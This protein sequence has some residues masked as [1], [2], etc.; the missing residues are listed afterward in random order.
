[1]LAQRAKHNLVTRSM[2]LFA[3]SAGFL[4]AQLVAMTR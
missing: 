2:V 4:I 3:L 1:M